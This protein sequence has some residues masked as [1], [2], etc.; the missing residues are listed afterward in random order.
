MSLDFSASLKRAVQNITVYG[1][2]D[3][4]P[5]PFEKHLFEDK[6]SECIEVLK[7]WHAD[8]NGCVADNPPVKVDAL[9]QVGY[10]GFRQVTEIEPFWNAYYLALV[11]RLAQGIEDLR[12]PAGENMVFSYRHASGDQSS[13][14]QDVTWID[15]RRRS[16]ELAESHEYVV[17]TD[18]ADF[19][20]RI[21]HHR[22]ENA[23]HRIPDAGGHASEN[24]ATS[25]DV[26]RGPVLWPSRR[27]ARVSVVGGALT[28][29]C[30]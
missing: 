15:Y 20:P 22:L 21:N 26:F 18:I 13:L 27:R 9:C 3:V 14:F 5:F 29:R 10:T 11:L 24:I 19:Y 16:V 25:V 8:F 6:P 30:R 1:D 12:I 23:L 2:T 4:F 28:G 7:R 17:L